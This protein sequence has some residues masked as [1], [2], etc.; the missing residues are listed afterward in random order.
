M[1]DTSCTSQCKLSNYCLQHTSTIAV[2]MWWTPLA[3]WLVYQVARVQAVV[4]EVAGTQVVDQVARVRGV[5]SSDRSSGAGSS[6][7]SSGAGSSD[8]SSGA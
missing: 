6:D 4:N 3:L 2:Y 8:R 7:R 5:G 1:Q